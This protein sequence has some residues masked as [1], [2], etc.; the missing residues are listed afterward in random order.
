M[1]R[2]VKLTVSSEGSIFQF[3]GTALACRYLVFPLP[4]PLVF[5]LNNRMHLCRGPS[6]HLRPVAETLMSLVQLL[7]LTSG[8]Q[9]FLPKT[10][11]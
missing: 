8:A 7:S 1:R 4:I 3:P 10:Q 5:A 6:A 11:T 2:E 9:S